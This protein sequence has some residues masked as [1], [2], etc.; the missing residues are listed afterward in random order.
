MNESNIFEKEFLTIAD[1]RDYLNISKSAA[2]ALV[3]R[4]DFPVAHFGGCVRVPTK[5]FL[6]WV[7]RN[8]YVPRSLKAVV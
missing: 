7:D 8:V 5:P 6:A 4:K 3:H 1:I 2:T